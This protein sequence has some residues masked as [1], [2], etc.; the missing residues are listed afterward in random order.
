MQG[1]REFVFYR[2]FN[3]HGGRNMSCKCTFMPGNENTKI[4]GYAPDEC[5]NQW[6]AI[7]NAREVLGLEDSKMQEILHAMNVED[8]ASLT[9]DDV[10]NYLNAP[11]YEEIIGE[12]LEEFERLSDEWFFKLR[13]DH[14]AG[15]KSYTTDGFADINP[16]L[17]NGGVGNLDLEKQISAIDNAINRFYLE[18]DVIAFRGDSAKYYKEW[19]VGEERTLDAYVST[20][21]DKEA[22]Q[23]YSNHIKHNLGETAINIEIRV[24]KDTKCAYIGHNTF[25]TESCPDVENEFELLLAHG[26]KFKVL[27]KTESHMILEVV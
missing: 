21:L 7:K 11:H 1:S 27:E 5:Y 16:Y 13:D 4:E 14:L 12:A 10:I 9:V 2:E 23:A 24:K 22:A 8:L 19:K 25:V 3:P 15:I 20:A 26:T 18:K 17:R 6:Q